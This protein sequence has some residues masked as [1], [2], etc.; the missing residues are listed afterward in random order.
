MRRRCKADGCYQN[1]CC[2]ANH[3]AERGEGEAE[4]LA[5]RQVDAFFPSGGRGRLHAYGLDATGS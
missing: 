4:Y 5:Q 2:G 1:Q 3:H